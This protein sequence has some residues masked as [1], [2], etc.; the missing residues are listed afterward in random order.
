MRWIQTQ[1]YTSTKLTILNSIPNLIIP[2]TAQDA[3][4]FIKKSSKRLDQPWANKND[5]KWKAFFAFNS[6]LAYDLA[7]LGAAAGQQQDEAQ[8]T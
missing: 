3:K 7:G 4:C 2:F 6:K 5:L 1:T 8:K